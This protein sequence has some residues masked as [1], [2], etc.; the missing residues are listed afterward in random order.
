MKEY[1]RLFLSLIFVIFI[2][3]RVQAKTPESI[4]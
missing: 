2:L 4:T 3:N 1:V